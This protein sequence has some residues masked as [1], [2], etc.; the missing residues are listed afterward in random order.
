M[1]RFRLPLI[2]TIAVA[3]AG[4][5]AWHEPERAEPVAKVSRFP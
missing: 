4:V 2:S 3:F 5:D 1:A